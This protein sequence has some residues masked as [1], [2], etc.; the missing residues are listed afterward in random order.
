MLGVS[1]GEQQKPEFLEILLPTAESWRC[2][3]SHAVAFTVMSQPVAFTVIEADLE[4]FSPGRVAAHGG[5]GRLVEGER[6]F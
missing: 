1:V 6:A 3:A 5:H 4:A 2:R